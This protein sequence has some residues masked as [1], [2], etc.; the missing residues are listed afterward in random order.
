MPPAVVGHTIR[1]ISFPRARACAGAFDDT[2]VKGGLPNGHR[3]RVLEFHHFAALAL[4]L[5]E[6]EIVVDP[7]QPSFRR[8]YGSSLVGDPRAHYQYQVRLEGGY[9]GLEGVG[10]RGR[11]C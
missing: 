4:A 1:D 6:F 7:G 2:C 11:V 5:D 8:T 9:R 3:H 10:G